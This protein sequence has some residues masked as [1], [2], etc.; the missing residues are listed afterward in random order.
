LRILLG[1]PWDDYDFI[2]YL[3]QD[4][5]A[6]RKASY[7]KLVNIRQCQSSDALEQSRLLS[8]IQH[9]NIATVC[10]LYCDG[11]KIF[12]VTEHFHISILQLE[13]QKYELEEWEI[14]TIIVEVLKGI[15]YISSLKLSCKNFSG[16]NVGLTL[17]GEIKLGEL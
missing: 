5:V 6:R 13:L 1:D 17:A 12:L 3:G 9:P 15:A 2:R 11:D 4:M 16:A 10:G 14:A 8:S 7:F